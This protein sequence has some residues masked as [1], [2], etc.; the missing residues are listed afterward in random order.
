MRDAT[1]ELQDAVAQARAT[2]ARRIEWVERGLLNHLETHAALDALIAAVRAECAA[3]PAVTDAMVEA[4]IAEFCSQTGDSYAML[5]ANASD[6]DKAE[7]RDDWRHILIAA[8]AARG[9]A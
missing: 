3:L 5:M 9:N 6:E 8:L 7:M 2:L 1:P 4:A